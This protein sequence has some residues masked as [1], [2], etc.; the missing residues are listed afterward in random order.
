MTYLGYI[1]EIC[2]VLLDNVI[3]GKTVPMTS[4]YIKYCTCWFNPFDVSHCPQWE[5]PQK[6]YYYDNRESQNQAPVIGNT[7][8]YDCSQKGKKVLK[9]KDITVEMLMIW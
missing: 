8:E 6:Y 3:K 9:I 1:L 5:L 4:Y 7:D 2:T